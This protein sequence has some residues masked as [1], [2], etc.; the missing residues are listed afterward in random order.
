M[1]NCAAGYCEL[2]AFRAMQS[3]FFFAFSRGC[4]FWRGDGRASQPCLQAIDSSQREAAIATS[5][6]RHGGDANAS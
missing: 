3:S 4:N 2:C 6:L 5:W 1:E